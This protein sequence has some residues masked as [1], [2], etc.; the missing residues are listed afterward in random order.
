MILGAPQPE[1]T[2]PDGARVPTIFDFLDEARRQEAL[3]A[4]QAERTRRWVQLNSIVRPAERFLR[5]TGL[6]RG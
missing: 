4:D 2:S 6:L 3:E 1:N 5:L